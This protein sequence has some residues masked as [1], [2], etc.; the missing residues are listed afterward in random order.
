MGI[1]FI[2][3]NSCLLGTFLKSF[4][5]RVTT[6]HGPTRVRNTRSDKLSHSKMVVDLKI[7]ASDKASTWKNSIPASHIQKY[8]DQISGEGRLTIPNQKL[9]PAILFMSTKFKSYR[10]QK[11]LIWINFTNFRGICS[12]Y[13]TIGHWFFCKSFAFLVGVF[14]MKITIS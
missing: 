13:I 6:S 9:W 14:V 3:I 8:S 10:E 1:S 4:F 2:K 11:L 7:S 5:S 12:L